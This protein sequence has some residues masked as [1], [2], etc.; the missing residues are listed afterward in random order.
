MNCCS[1][2]FLDSEIIG[3]INY[4]SNNVGNCDFC[5]SNQVSLV[6]TKELQGQFTDLFDIYL[7]NKEEGLPSIEV[8][9]NDWNIFKISDSN[10]INALVTSIIDD[11]ETIYTEKLNS[12]LSLSISKETQ[13]LINDWNSFKKEIKEENRFFFKNNVELKEIEET[14]PFRTYNK[15]KIFYRSR[16]CDTEQGF[17]AE[18]MGKPP[19]KITRSGRANP[20]GIPYLYLA[21][22]IDTT[23]YESRSTFLDYVSVG[24]FKLKENIKVI[25]LRTTYQ[26]SPFVDDFSLEKYIKNKPF[27]DVLEHDLAKPLRRNDNELDYLPTQYLCK[28]IKSLGYDGVEYGSAMHQEGINIVIFND[29]KVECINTMVY[30]VSQIDIKSNKV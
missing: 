8:F 21:Q 20:Q 14:L 13:D 10:T 18:L 23:L 7:I 15:G 1:N 29:S 30:E 22:S 24:E 6:N 12:K 17:K 27:I 19:K 26:V 3:F 4:N 16:I 2:C 11:L 5:N 28:Y 9:Q 25:T